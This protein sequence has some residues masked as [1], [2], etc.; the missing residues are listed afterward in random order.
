M[1]SENLA[2]CLSR[3]SGGLRYSG[4]PGGAW[5]QGARVASG[6]SMTGVGCSSA[7]SQGNIAKSPSWVPWYRR[8]PKLQTPVDTRNYK[9]LISV[10]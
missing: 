7:T 10:N 1:Q 4:P 5:L 9:I 3:N 6:F 2:E 8:G